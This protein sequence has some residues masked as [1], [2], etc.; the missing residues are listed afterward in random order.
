MHISEIFLLFSA[1]KLKLNSKILIYTMSIF[2]KNFL[3][4]SLIKNYL[5]F[6][7]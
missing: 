5:N 6:K 7:N 4:N 1:R 2:T 3:F